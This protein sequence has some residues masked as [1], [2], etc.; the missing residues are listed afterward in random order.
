MNTHKYINFQNKMYFQKTI[1]QYILCSSA[2]D[3][4]IDYQQESSVIYVRWT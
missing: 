4:V 2:W 3:L 1:K